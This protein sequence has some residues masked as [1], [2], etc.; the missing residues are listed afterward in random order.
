[1]LDAS[2]TATAGVAATHTHCSALHNHPRA[3]SDA[4][5]DALAAL[6]TPPKPITI[7]S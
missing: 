7:L 2:E 1:M 4:K 5:L 6:P 3:K